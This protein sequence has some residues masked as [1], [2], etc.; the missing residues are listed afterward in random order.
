MRN[1]VSTSKPNAVFARLNSGRVASWNGRQRPRHGTARALLD[2]GSSDEVALL[3][4]RVAAHFLNSLPSH[5]RFSP[6]AG[7]PGSKNASE[8][9]ETYAID[10][11]AA[12]ITTTFLPYP[13]PSAR[14]PVLVRSINLRQEI[15]SSRL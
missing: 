14:V 3:R 8:R 12:S 15:T 6:V 7:A 10:Q 1:R 13:F 4:V 9:A 11:D 5:T 2:A